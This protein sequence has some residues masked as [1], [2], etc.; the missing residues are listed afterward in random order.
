MVLPINKNTPNYFYNKMLIIFS[1]ALFNKTDI[2]RHCLLS[3]LY[4]I[5][6]LEIKIWIY[7]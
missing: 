3:K 6:T 1:R 5:E 7:K 2:I 4:G